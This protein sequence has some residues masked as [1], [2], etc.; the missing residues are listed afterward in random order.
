VQGLLAHWAG[1]TAMGV[2]ACV[3][4]LCSASE[5]AL[6]SLNGRQRRKLASDRRGRTAILLLEDPDRLLTA[7]LFWNL[8]VNLAYFAVAS[9]I[10]LRLE[11]SGSSAAAAAMAFGSLL[12]LILFGEMLPKSVGVLMPGPLAGLLAVPLSGLV[13]LLAPVLPALRTANLLS[14]RLFCPRFKAEPHL[15]IG[16]LERA[17]ELSTQNAA[18]LAQEQLVLQNIVALSEIR[19]D[20]LMR[21]RNSCRTFRPPVVLA[22]LKGQMPSSGYLL[23]TEPDSEEIAK[24]IP[25]KS[26]SRVP[27]EHLEDHAEAVVYVPWCTTVAD[28]LEVMFRGPWRVAAVINEYGETIG[29]LT[30]DDVLDTI[31]SKASSRVERILSRQPL[32]QVGPDRWHVDGM[33]GLRR[34]RRQFTLDGPPCRS[35][36]V[37][38]VIQ[39]ILDRLPAEGDECTWGPFHFRVLRTSERVP[40]L[41]ELTLAPPPRE[42]VR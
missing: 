13:R 40:Q 39:E 36:T 32:R 35:V 33:T 38:G 21:P 28:A 2:L 42:V 26:L 4:A 22:D 20:E 25:L 31:F 23:V 29:I 8:I 5:A 24:A 15:R 30:E 17:V 16:D 34:L 19:V 10:S 37:A 41:I 1:L 9:M 27:S 11:R 18:L 3:S 7:V 6:F 14:R 12:V